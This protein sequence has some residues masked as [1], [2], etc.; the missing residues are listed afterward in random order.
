MIANL[1]K[2]AGFRGALDYLMRT[3]RDEPPGQVIGGNM[4]AR[5]ARELAAEFKT[6]RL[7]RQDV[8]RPVWHASLSIPPGI[9]LS[10]E[11][12][13]KA[14]RVF[15]KEMGF[16][17]DRNQFVLIRHDDRDHQHIHILASRIDIGNGRLVREGRGDYRQSHQAAA[18][19]AQ[20]VGLPP[21]NPAPRPERKATLT[22]TE[23]AHADRVGQP[24]PKLQIASRLDA[25]LALSKSLDEFKSVAADHGVDVKF[26]SNSGGIYGVS[27]RL[28]DPAARPDFDAEWLKG[29]QV[30][31]GYTLPSIRQRLASEAIGMNHQST[32]KEHEH[33]SR[34]SRKPDPRRDRTP[35]PPRARHRLRGLSQLDV[36]SAGEQ[37]SEMLL[38]GDVHHRL[39]RQ[40]EERIDSLR[41]R[42]QDYRSGLTTRERYEGGVDVVRWRSGIVAATGT[43]QE[44]R[45]RT[46]SAA[47]SQIVAALAAER[48]WNAIEMAD[49]GSDEKNQAAIAAYHANGIEVLLNGRHIPAPS[50]SNADRDDAS[51]AA[52]SRGLDAA[53]AHPVGAS[54]GR[55]GADP[56]GDAGATAEAR[57]S[58]ANRPAAD[59][60]A[61]AAASAAARRSA[62]AD[63]EDRPDRDPNGKALDSTT[64]EEKIM[65]DSLDFLNEN[66]ELNDAE[67]KAADEYQ[68]LADFYNNELNEAEGRQMRE[69]EEAGLAR[70]A[71][72]ALTA[73]TSRAAYRDLLQ[74][75]RHAPGEVSTQQGL[76]DQAEQL[77][78]RA[79]EL[80]LARDQL[81]LAIDAAR[82]LNPD[83]YAYDS[84]PIH[85]LYPQEYNDLEELYELEQAHRGE[86]K[87]CQRRAAIRIPTA[88][89]QDAALQRALDH[90]FARRRWARAEAVAVDLEGRRQELE[91]IKLQSWGRRLLSAARGQQALL[92]GEIQRLEAA[93]RQAL[94]REAGVMKSLRADPVSQGLIQEEAQATAAERA[95]IREEAERVLAAREAQSEAQREAALLRE[96]EAEQDKDEPRPRKK[97]GG[98]AAPKPR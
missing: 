38:Q 53:P 69:D 54:A 98:P 18:K 85:P 32:T 25:A 10:N 37:R 91:W 29:S 51:G 61:A 90:E 49:R 2:G 74:R 15:I 60:T 72:E 56:S 87:E 35:P 94:A 50:G 77:L 82:T 97:S 70:A 17:E 30:G 67:T 43:D 59:A 96:R 8:K 66:N 27:Y 79:D 64:T 9:A 57:S 58:V 86:A 23:L 80:K 93:H 6:S 39:E 83:H 63:L 76:R 12:W 22:R 3:S 95:A 55:I 1:T 11:E 26:S 65:V 42:G 78:D 5:D 21:V 89:D 4:A 71:A 13:D 44:I 48:G 31:K 16:D 52:A 45:W 92:K 19:A 34:N 40:R 14:A 73:A 62:G 7:L 47:E 88:E 68:R 75:A 84:D 24:H 33:D 28:A 20:A 41:R 81:Q 46:G 36:V